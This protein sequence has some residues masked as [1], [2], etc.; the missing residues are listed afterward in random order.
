M[1]VLWRVVEG[2]LEEARKG[3]RPKGEGRLS[4]TEMGSLCPRHGEQQMQGTKGE[5][6]HCH[7]SYLSLDLIGEWEVGDRQAGPVGCAEERA[8]LLR[9]QGTE[10]RFRAEE[11]TDVVQRRWVGGAGEGE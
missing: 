1:H 8:S 10:E 4:W 9:V 2:P 6:R 7:R 5:G 3:L 11:E